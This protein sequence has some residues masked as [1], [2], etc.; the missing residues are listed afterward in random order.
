MRKC[1]N[2]E[3][4]EGFV[5]ASVLTFIPLVI[6]LSMIVIGVSLQSYRSS[7]NQEL[8][9]QAQLASTA[10][11]DFAK[12]QYELDQNYVGTAETLLYS[13]DQHDV[14]FEVIHDEFTNPT[15]TQ[16]DIRG[17]GRMYKKGTTELLYE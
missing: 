6:L 13:T 4:Q 11:M 12:E 5:L 9:R 7:L 17:V 1:D 8:I 15:N 16:Q 2:V 10:A 3:Q 14:K